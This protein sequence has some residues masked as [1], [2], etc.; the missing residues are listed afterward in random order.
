MYC[1]STMKN[2][3]RHDGFKIFYIVIDLR[4]RRRYCGTYH[5]VFIYNHRII[6][7]VQ[8]VFDVFGR[9]PSRTTVLDRRTDKL[10]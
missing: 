1:T 7:V 2:R 4:Y 10:Y 9:H 8:T 5:I 6:I 3:N